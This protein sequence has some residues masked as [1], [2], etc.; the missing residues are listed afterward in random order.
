MT[1]QIYRSTELA[2]RITALLNA[3]TIGEADQSLV[4]RFE[5]A[6]LADL[7]VDGPSGVEQCSVE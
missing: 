7:L 1:Q 6:E 3:S 5:R 4:F 2:D